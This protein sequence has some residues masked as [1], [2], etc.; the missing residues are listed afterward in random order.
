ML[1]NLML[2]Q[3]VRTVI[4]G[5]IIQGDLKY[6]D[7]LRYLHNDYPLAPAKRGILYDMLLNYCRKVSD[8]YGI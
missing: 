7:E 8:K 2:I 6:P 5:C 3:L 4:K 1:I